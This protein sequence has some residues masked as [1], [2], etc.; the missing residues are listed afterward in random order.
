MDKVSGA[1]TSK[2]SLKTIL[3]TDY[4]AFYSILVPPVAWLV[5][6]AWSVDWWGS[7]PVIPIFARP[8]YLALVIIV[9]LVSLVVLIWRVRLIQT[10]F[11]KGTPVRGK[12]ASFRMKGARGK[13]EYTFIY[14]H[15]ECAARTTVHR[16]RLTKMLRK[17]DLVD[18]IVDRE[19]PKI[20]LIRDLYL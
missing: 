10:L 12:I 13:V 6:F 14:H 15:K 9:T 17:G 2:P 18:L 20:A 7:G 3:W 5:F 8:G 11:A 16:N 19:N 1:L 4:T